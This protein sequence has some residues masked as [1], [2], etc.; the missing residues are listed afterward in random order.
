[1]K[2]NIHVKIVIFKCVIIAGPKA[3]NWIQVVKDPYSVQYFVDIGVINNCPNMVS[4]GEC[5]NMVSECES[6][7]PI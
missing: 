3:M 2:T 7:Y 6:V 1:M 4:E 5:P